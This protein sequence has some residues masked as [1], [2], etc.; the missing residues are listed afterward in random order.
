MLKKFLQ[1]ILMM[2]LLQMPA[3]ASLSSHLSKQDIAEVLTYLPTFMEYENFL[4]DEMTAS[5]MTSFE[6]LLEKRGFIV[7]YDWPSWQ[8]K[9][10]FFYYNPLLLAEADLD[11]IVR[12]FTLHVRK[13]QY[14][15][16]HFHEMAQ[17]GHITAILH[18]LEEIQNARAE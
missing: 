14:C 9:A 8:D 18:R 17:K 4:N 11:D 10:I 15:E 6:C 16:G 7:P 13:D 5:N 3:W 2:M 12:L 1:M